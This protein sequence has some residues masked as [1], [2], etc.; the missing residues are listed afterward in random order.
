MCDKCETFLLSLTSLF[1]TERT[2][3]FSVTLSFLA[4]FF[5]FFKGW[6]AVVYY[7]VF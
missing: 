5:K 3:T 1:G 7:V 6:E 2:L 4:S